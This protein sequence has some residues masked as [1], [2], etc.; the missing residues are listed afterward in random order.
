MIKKIEEIDIQKLFI[1]P[2]R[3]FI[4]NDYRLEF[5]TYYIDKKKL[6][7]IAKLY[8]AVDYEIYP[9]D[10]DGPYILIIFWKKIPN[11]YKIIK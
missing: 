1:E 3:N 8:G 11:E 4:C 10:K 9:E 5:E 2:I 6:D 7:E